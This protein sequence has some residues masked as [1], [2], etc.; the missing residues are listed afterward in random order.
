MAYPPKWCV[1]NR[2]SP[3]EFSRL[4][5]RISIFAMSECLIRLIKGKK[6]SHNMQSTLHGIEKQ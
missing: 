5:V 4:N 6:V 1:G 3:R 2:Y